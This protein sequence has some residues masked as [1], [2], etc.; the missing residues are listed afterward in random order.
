MN[1]SVVDLESDGLL[2]TITKIHCVCA[3]RFRDGKEEQLVL[4]N[5]EDMRR[6]FEEEEVI[7]GHNIIEFDIPAVKKILGVTYRGRAI[8]TLGL[9]RYIHPERDSHALGEWGYDLH[10]E[11]PPIDD[12]TNLET[13]DYVFRCSEDV[14]INVALFY[15]LI[16]HLRLIYNDN[17]DDIDRLINYLMFKMECAREQ[18]EMR[19]KLDEQACRDNLAHLE[20]EYQ[21][22]KQA[23]S[24]LMPPDIKYKLVARPK[25]LYRK[26][27]SISI[28]GQKWLDLLELKGLPSYHMGTIQ[29]EHSRKPGNPRSHQQIKAWLFSLGWVPDLYKYIRELDGSMRRIPQIST[30]EAE[31]TESVM[32][33]VEN[34]PE[35]GELNG[36]YS[37]GSRMGILQGFLRDVDKDGYLVAGTQGF[38][39]TLRFQHA[40][41]VN[42]PTSEKLYGEYVRSCLIA[43]SEDYVLC[44]SDMKGLEDNTKRHYMY[45]YDPEYVKEMMEDGFDPHLDIAVLAGMLTPEQAE[46]HKLYERTKGKEGVSHKPIRAKAK[47]VNFGGIYGA[48]V[49]KLALTGGFSM[50]EAKKLYVTYWKRNWSVKRVAED[51]ITKTIGEQMWLFNPVSQLWYSLRAFKDRFSTLNQGT[52]VYCF[53][54]WIKKVRAKGIRICG[55]FHDEIIFPVKKGEEECTK[56]KLLQAID[57]V[58]EQLKLN[59]KLGISIDFGNNYSEIH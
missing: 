26:D 56:I 45:F 15:N 42:L 34:M 36:L 27:E 11:K 59:V 4:L 46:E 30:P 32:E 3:T 47:K 40:V 6:F 20:D 22:K 1:Y 24:A 8:D 21:K 43:P 16:Y 44:G 50:S 19:W 48:G 2:D 58:N 10:I 37:I 13:V 5:Y 33:L 18:V 35:L 14:R 57:E 39:N 49:A 29:V 51:S 23:V 31:L 52:G 25:T 7:V 41:L 55:Q 28:A 38:T 54:C 9:S 53:D 12:W 17:R